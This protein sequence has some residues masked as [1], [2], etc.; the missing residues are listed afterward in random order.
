MAPARAGLP[1][2][3]DS[4]A[5]RHL[6]V[7]KDRANP[8]AGTLDHRYQYFPPTAPGRPT[9]VLLPGGPGPGIYDWNAKEVADA[10]QLPEGFGMLSLDPRGIGCNRVGLK[11]I[12]ARLY[13]TRKLAEDTAEI[14]ARERL[15]NFVLFGGS[16]GTQWATELY[17][18]LRE[19]KLPLPRLVILEGTL[20]RAWPV[21]R[22]QTVDFEHQWKVQ[23][24]EL[25]AKVLGLFKAKR[26]PFDLD[27][28]TWGK[29][30]HDQ[31]LFGTYLGKDGTTVHRSLPDAL[32]PL[33]TGTSEEKEKLKEEVVSSAREPQEPPRGT[34]DEL[35]TRTV[36]CRE[37]RPEWLI[38]MEVRDG[39]LVSIARRSRYCEG[40]PFDLEY[41]ADHVQILSPIVYLEG[42]R[43]PATPYWQSGAH[44]AGQRHASKKVYLQLPKGGHASGLGIRDCLKAFWKASFALANDGEDARGFPILEKVCRLRPIVTIR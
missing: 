42:A 9:F 15:K 25:S 30:L 36:L 13:S 5:I 11:E 26:L 22:G 43:D 8:R 37:T 44:F 19:R 2:Y 31:L 14:I 23:S 32:E 16:Y 1:A 34:S 33:V 28:R 12:P 21:G 7:P 38:P 29:Y 10:W 17:G 40:T 41:S 27:A 6:S 3:C 39:L 35:M 4:P 20:G 18:V 24:R